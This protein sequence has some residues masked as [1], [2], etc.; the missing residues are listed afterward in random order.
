MSPTSGQAPEPGAVLDIAPLVKPPRAEVRVPG[1]KSLTNRALV[2]AALAHGRSV[3][4][5]ALFSDDS[6]HLADSL[7]R[8]GFRVEQDADNSRVAVGGLG[9]RIPASRA[10]LFVGNAGTAAR[11]L[12]AMLTLGQGEYVLDGVPRMRERPIADLLD[13]LTMLG[14]E[15]TAIHGNGCPPVRVRANGL[16]GG[17]GTVAGD[18]SS[19]FL[20]GLL[21][22]APHAR[23]EVSI[24]VLGP[25]VAKPYVDMTIA[26]MAD[27]GV[28]VEREAYRRFWVRAGQQYRARDYEIESDAS[29]ASY[30]FAAAAVTGGVVRVNGISSRSKQGD[31]RFL[32]VLRAMGCAV[33]EAADWVQVTGPDRLEGVD[34]DMTEISDTS[35]TLAAIAP[36]ASG[37]VRVRGIGHARLQESDRVAAVVTELRRLGVEA[38]EMPDGF[39]VSPVDEIRPASIETYNDHRMAMAFSILGLRAP[40]VSITNPTCVSKTFPGFFQVLER[41]RD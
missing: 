39:T 1:S 23:R 29:S 27:F 24:E 7:G 30:F 14:A 2:V 17:H 16:P 12:T 28:E 6:F 40:G 19:Q 11:F 35:L 32:G 31:I 26:L 41:L 5:N 10:E 34:V 9:G 18:R 33:D 3:L 37:P 13:A 4:S 21:L 20:S 36:F 22:A 8:L 25:L 15:V 38:Q